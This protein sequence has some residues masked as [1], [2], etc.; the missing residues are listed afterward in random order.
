MTDIFN[1][2]RINIGH[3]FFAFHELQKLGSHDSFT[4]LVVIIAVAV[5]RFCWEGIGI[6]TL[7]WG[8]EEGTN[9]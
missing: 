1:N 6:G 9:A 8:L 7:T 2:S 3:L 5:L 4:M